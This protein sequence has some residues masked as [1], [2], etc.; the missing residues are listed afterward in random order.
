M[1]NLASFSISRSRKAVTGSTNGK[2]PLGFAS[3]DL[4]D[5]NL[6]EVLSLPDSS[7]A[8]IDFKARL[9]AAQRKVKNHPAYFAPRGNT[10]DYVKNI[11]LC[12]FCNHSLAIALLSC[13][14]WSHGDECCRYSRVCLRCNYS[15]EQLPIKN[16]LSDAYIDGRT[17]LHCTASGGSPVTVD[18]AESLDDC[19]LGFEAFRDAG[20]ELTYVP[21]KDSRK[22]REKRCFEG[23][24][25]FHEVELTGL[26]PVVT[27]APRSHLLVQVMK[28]VCAKD[29]TQ[30][31]REAY[32]RCLRDRR[33]AGTVERSLKSIELTKTNFDSFLRYR[34]PV[35][36]VP[37]YAA[38][39]LRLDVTLPDLNRNLLH[40][41]H[42]I[43]AFADSGSVPPFTTSGCFTA[44]SSNPRCKLIKE[45]ERELEQLA[46]DRYSGLDGQA[47]EGPFDAADIVRD[48]VS[49]EDSE[50][51]TLGPI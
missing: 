17:Y 31:L 35:D 33:S 5:K 45:L 14:D 20:E 2:Q 27:V 13:R 24:M 11:A 36:F 6:L 29:A 10:F 8:V 39:L 22:R 12:C 51:V 48:H 9:S 40:A 21:N 7:Q 42:F 16:A 15:F 28:G 38:A 43:D 46:S 19:A 44:R 47:D 50:G 26:Y 18:S 34:K 32:L 1:K 37:P 41:F 3:T 25:I 4:Y 30:R 23:C 49:D